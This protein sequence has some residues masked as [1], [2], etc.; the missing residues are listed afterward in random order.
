MA[1]R[2]AAQRRAEAKAD[3]DAFLA[4]CPSRVVFDMLSDKWVGLLLAALSGGTRR[5]GELR[6]EIAGVSPKMLT[7][8]LRTLE[9]SELVERTVTAQ[10]PVRVDYTLT[11]LGRGLFP[12]LAAIKNWAEQNVEAVHAAERAYDTRIAADH[13][14]TSIHSPATPGFTATLP[15]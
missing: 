10:V 14:P 5:Y 3:Y 12:L 2:S 15:G 9:R 13:P 1:T 6:T 8:T 7:Q 11:E 4:A